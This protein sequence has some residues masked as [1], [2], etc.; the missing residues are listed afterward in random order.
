MKTAARHVRLGLLFGLCA[1]GALLA[2]D[3]SPARVTVVFSHP[4]KYADL[5]DGFSDNENERG[6]ERYLP[7]IQEY[8]EREAGRRLPAGQQLTVTFTDIDLAGDFEPWRG[9]QF[10]DVRIVKDLYVPRLVFAFKVTDATGKVLKE[11]ERKLV[12]LGFQMRITAGFRDDQLR[13]E[14][15]MLGNW[16]REEFPARKG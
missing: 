13:Y 9:I 4:E 15:D 1:V 6:S 12:D 8:L 5:K 3:S 2:A 14:K 16:L 10:D 7:F 11:G